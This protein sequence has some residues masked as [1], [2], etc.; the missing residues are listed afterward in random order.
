MEH[1]RRSGHPSREEL[2]R[3]VDEPPTGPEKSHLEACPECREELEALRDQTAAL[4]SL[5]DLMPARGDWDA[6]EGR[7]VS[8]GLIRSRPA[9]VGG[10]RPPG[11]WSRIAAALVIFAA[12]SALGAGIS[13]GT[14][15]PF[16]EGT[17]T[18]G[19]LPVREASDP[20]EAAEILQTAEQQYMTALLQYRRMAGFDPDGDVSSDPVSRFAALEA[21]LSASQAALREAPADPFLNGVLVSTLAERQ[22]TLQQISSAEGNWF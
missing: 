8:E 15:D 12:G 21:L 11:G 5:P 18:A 13:E 20:E 14:P 19:V 7:M 4:G 2:A 3:L 10:V 6:L 1:M 22:A 16:P 17:R 9:G